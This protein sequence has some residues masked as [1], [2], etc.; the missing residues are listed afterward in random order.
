MKL[1]TV[2]MD[3][4]AAYDLIDHSILLRKMETLGFQPSGISWFKHYL[5][6][7]Q[8]L[9]YIDGASSDILH[10]GNRSVIQGSV[11]SCALYLL[12]ILY[13]PT[14]ILQFTGIQWLKSD[15]CTKPSLQRFVDDIM[16][17]IHKA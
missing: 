12:Y 1:A 9:V 10:I 2:A 7:R 15:L 4:S 16:S 3:Q 5:R 6:D 17:T 14:N 8:Q 11:L 13:L